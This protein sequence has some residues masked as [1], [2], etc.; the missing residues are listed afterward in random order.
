MVREINQFGQFFNGIGPALEVFTFASTLVGTAAGVA[1][2][3]Y[4]T[5]TY[6][7]EE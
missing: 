1:G 4:F 6:P 3:I 5:E 2:G 7:S